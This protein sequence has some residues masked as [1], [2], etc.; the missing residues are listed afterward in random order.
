M[1]F[2]KCFSTL[3]YSVTLGRF[4]HARKGLNFNETHQLLAYADDINLLDENIRTCIH[5]L[6]TYIHTS[7][8]RKYIHALYTY[9]NTGV[10]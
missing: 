3:L 2:L 1:F 4:K 10:W 6:H 7:R 8:I 9:I 5:I